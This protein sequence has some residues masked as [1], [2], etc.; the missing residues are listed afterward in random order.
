MDMKL[1]LVPVP[2]TDIDRAKAFYVEKVGFHADLDIRPTET[3][4][5]VQLTPPGSACSIVLS[6]GLDGI[7]MQPGSLRGLHLVVGDVY[8][9]REALISR[10]VEVGEVDEHDQGIKYAAFSD[11]DG[12]TWTFQEMPWR[13]SEFSL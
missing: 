5:I 6:T 13:S 4:R 3:V 8:K 9:A 11:P 12:N 1:E 10:G 2:V 7:K